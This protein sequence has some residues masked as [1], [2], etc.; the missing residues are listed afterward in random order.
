MIR[1][2]LL[3]LAAVVAAVSVA[4]GVIAATGSP[5]GP[6]RGQEQRFEAAVVPLVTE[7]GRVVEEGMKPAL[8]DLTTDHVT[9]PAFIAT[10]AAQWQATLTRVG[11]QLGTVRASGRL[12]RARD[13]LVA[14]LA[15]YADAAASFHAAALASGS[16]RDQL[17]D[18]G[19]ATAKRGDATYDKGATIVQAVRRS[20]GLGPSASFP[21]PGHE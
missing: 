19:I 12:D 2:R 10:E 16:R 15:T 11:Q 9:P 1:F 5:S 8:H 18:E 20:L 14:A 17:I 21:D 7:G 4:A 6:T 13:R 3:L